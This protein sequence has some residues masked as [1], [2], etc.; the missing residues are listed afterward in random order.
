[1][2]ATALTN[3]RSRQQWA[4]IIGA[5]WR[6]SIESIIQTGRD[7]IAAKQ[8]LAHGEFTEMVERDLP[9]TGAAAAQLMRVAAH[10]SIADFRNSK[11]LPARVSV[12]IEL[13]SLSEEDFA[14]AEEKGLITPDL[15]VKPARSI[16]GAYNKPEGEII[17]GAQHMLPSPKEAREIARA[18]GRFVAASDGQI[19][20]GATKEEGRDYRDKRTVAFRILE[21][22][23]ILADAPE[24]SDWL[25]GTERHWF[26]GFDPNSIGE[27]RKWLRA[28][29]EATEAVDA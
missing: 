13:S 3:A 19:Y 22:I 10:P 16:A 27:A 18:T 11:I 26:E 4:E 6:K 24:V 9:F 14:D 5:D 29:E 1:M 7:L 25:A 23:Q 20:S 28:F 2:P 15:K 8:E 12:L 17:G 21:A